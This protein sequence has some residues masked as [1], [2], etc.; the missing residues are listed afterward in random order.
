MSCLFQENKSYG[1]NHCIDPLSTRS[2]TSHPEHEGIWIYPLI[3]QLLGL[4]DL[5]IET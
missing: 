5:R 4:L 2:C 1:V 3:I